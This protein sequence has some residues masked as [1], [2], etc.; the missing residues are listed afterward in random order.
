M[1]LLTAFYMVRLTMKGTR[2]DVDDD[3]RM[4]RLLEPD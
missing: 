2:D 4:L 1:V 3:A